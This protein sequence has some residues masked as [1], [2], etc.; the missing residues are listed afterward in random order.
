[1]TLSTNQK[2]RKPELREYNHA[3]DSRDR[4]LVHLVETD[5]EMPYVFGLENCVH[6][7]DVDHV[8]TGASGLPELR[9]VAGGPLEREI[10]GVIAEEI[11]DGACLQIGIGAMPNAVCE[12]LV[13]APVKYLGVHTEMFVD[14]LMSLYEAGK[15][16]QPLGLPPM[17]RVDQKA[18]TALA[19]LA[20]LWCSATQ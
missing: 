9:N 20:M 2:W 10:A 19:M 14:S 11:E 17:R 6:I 4:A 18:R 3:V 7:S 1:M 8:I 5:P 15:T 12:M 13:D 16:A